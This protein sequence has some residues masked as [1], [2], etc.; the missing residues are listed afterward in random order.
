[1]LYSQLVQQRL[2]H[3]AFPRLGCHQVP[4]VAYLALANAVDAAKALLHAVGVPG[5]VVIDHEVG[6]LQVHAFASGIGGQQHQH[7]GVVAEGFLHLAPV[8]AVDAAVDGDHGLFAAQRVADA[9]QQVV[10]RVA[11]LGEDDDFAAAA[12][13]GAHLGLVLQQARELFPLAVA[14]R[15]HDGGGGAFQLPQDQN[16]SLQ[17]RDGL[18]SGGLVHHL[19]GHGFVFFGAEFVG[20]IV[21]VVG[22]VELALDDV[23]PQVLAQHIGSGLELQLI[24]TGFELFAPARQRC[25]D[26]LRA[27]GQ[28]ALQLGQGKAHGALALAVQPV[29]TIHLIAHVVGNLVVEQHLG[30]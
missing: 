2:E 16:F 27:G 26:G 18:G 3:F 15:L 11:V 30:I 12:I 29:S 19:V 8:V 21:Q 7:V 5:Q 13:G 17:L 14:A 23:F 24:Q 10:E 28:A 4:Q 22:Q 20:G 9:Q 25:V 6:V 1:M